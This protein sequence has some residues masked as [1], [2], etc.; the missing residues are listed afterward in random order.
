[1]RTSETVQTEEPRFST[2]T[3]DSTVYSVENSV[4]TVENKRFF[5]LCPRM[6]KLV[7]SF[8]GRLSQT[9]AVRGITGASVR[10]G[11]A[12]SRTV[13]PSRTAFAG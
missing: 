4:E 10:N 13:F 6:W 1:M 2:K 12:V 5:H 7:E 11:A 3:R 9:P 8:A